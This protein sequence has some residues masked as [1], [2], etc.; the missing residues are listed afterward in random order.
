MPKVHFWGGEHH[1]PQYEGG[2]VTVTF[3]AAVGSLD[4]LR[5][6]CDQH[7]VKRPSKPYQSK[8]GRAEWEAAA[9]RPGVLV[10]RNEEPTGDQSDDWQA[11][12]S[13]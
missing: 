11:L 3:A 5:R 13:D 12:P 9:A 10:Y 2:W 1:S 6:L 7:Q 8:P 4:E